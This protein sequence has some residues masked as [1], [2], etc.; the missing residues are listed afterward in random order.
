MEIQ[1]LKQK[2]VNPLIMGEA[3][4][5]PILQRCSSML[6]YFFLTEPISVMTGLS[7]SKVLDL[8][9]QTIFL[10]GHTNLCGHQTCMSKLDCFMAAKW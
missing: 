8:Y 5:V 9:F 1:I 3:L 6:H 2:I 10:L 7:I 4:G